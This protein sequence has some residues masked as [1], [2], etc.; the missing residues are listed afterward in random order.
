MRGQGLYVGCGTGRNYVPLVDA[1]LKLTGLDVSKEAIVQLRA[2]HP[3]LAQDLV[4]ADGH[5]AGRSGRF[6]SQVR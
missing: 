4:Q 3:H 6:H 2:R 5:R 1:G